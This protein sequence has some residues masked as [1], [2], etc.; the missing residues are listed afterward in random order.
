MKSFLVSAVL[1]SGAWVHRLV[2]LDLDRSA[3]IHEIREKAILQL[4]ESEPS[5]ILPWLGVRILEVVGEV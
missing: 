2:D 1:V 3:T 4:A 5:G